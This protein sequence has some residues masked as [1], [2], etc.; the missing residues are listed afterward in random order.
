MEIVDGDFFLFLRRLLR[1]RDS[2]A[3]LREVLQDYLFDKWGNRN[4]FCLESIDS[5]ISGGP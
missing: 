5:S 2:V 1:E 4:Q 3:H